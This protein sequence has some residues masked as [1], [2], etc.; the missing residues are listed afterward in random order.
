[1]EV[2]DLELVDTDLVAFHGG[3]TD[4]TWGYTSDSGLSGK[5]ARFDLATFSH[6]EVL[7]LPSFDSDLENFRGGFTDVRR[8]I[9]RGTFS[10]PR[11]PHLHS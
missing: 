6:V 4:G 2:L 9:E 3:F 7:D 1:M 8:R 11:T 10:Q 5:M